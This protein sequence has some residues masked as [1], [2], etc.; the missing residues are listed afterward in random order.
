MLASLLNFT[1]LLKATDTCWRAWQ[2]VTVIFALLVW[3][4]REAPSSCPWWW[5]ALCCA[6]WAAGTCWWSAGR[7]R[8]AGSSTARCCPTPPSP[9]A[10]PASRYCLM[11]SSETS[12]ESPVQSLRDETLLIV[13][14][15]YSKMYSAN[16]WVRQRR[17]SESPA[18]SCAIHGAALAD[19]AIAK[20]LRSCPDSKSEPLEETLAD[21]QKLFVFISFC[22][23]SLTWSRGLARKTSQ[24]LLP[25]GS[26]L[27][28]PRSE[29]TFWNAG[30]QSCLLTQ[31]PNC[32]SFCKSS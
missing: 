3:C 16:S 9:C 20:N 18:L 13:E 28:L 31:L 22:S 15:S 17:S 2:L 4:S 10:R 30:I 26:V 19:L 23:V 32:P 5:A 24:W 12:T 21:Q 1:L 29:M 27:L 7:A 6:P 14:T 25:C 8:C 11:H